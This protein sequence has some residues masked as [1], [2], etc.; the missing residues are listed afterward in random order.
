M[1]ATADYAA[2]KAILG[3]PLPPYV[4]YRDVSHAGAGPFAKDEDQTIVVRTRDGKVVRGKVPSIQ[5]GSHSK[6][7][8][9]RDVVDKPPFEPA[10]YAAE[11]ARTATFDGQTVEAVALRDICDRNRD[12]G[13]F[14]V[15]YVEPRTHDPIAASGDNTDQSV[16]VRVVQG[17]APFSGFFMPTS[18]DVRVQGSGW[19][20]H[21]YEHLS[22]YKFSATKP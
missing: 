8:Y 20:V 15:I 6:T 7:N 17:F 22:D 9:N 3:R 12:S 5:I 2:I 10:C 18:L 13:D 11:S 1:D 21:A 14:N 4:S 19:N 16:S